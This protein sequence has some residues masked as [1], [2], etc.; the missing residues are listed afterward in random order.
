[1]NHAA[2]LAALLASA[3]LAGCSQSGGGGDGNGTAT[4][5]A[6]T[7]CSLHSA[8]IPARVMVGVAFQFDSN[9]E[10]VG[11]WTSDHVGA[12]IASAASPTPE[13]GSIGAYTIAC[14]H[15]AETATT[16]TTPTSCTLM[17]AGTFY[18]RGHA[19]VNMGGSTQ[20]VWGGEYLVTA[21]NQGS[22]PPPGQPQVLVYDVPSTVAAGAMFV[23]PLKVEWGSVAQQVNS[24]HVGAHYG[25]TSQAT[26]PTVAGYGNGCSHYSGPIPGQFQISC[27]LG[28]A[29][30]TYLR[31][32]ARFEN[33]G[34]ML[35]YWS[36]ELAVSVT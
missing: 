10:C 12:H 2:W 32:H 21:A 19:R 3:L 9:P 36:D 25:G 4:T 26:N 24:D 22:E 5:T 6:A 30:T 8:R 35:D 16:A 29:G 27:T 7:G 20:E 34:Q 31:G 13:A 14:E 28:P 18:V 15:H 33:G 23:M 11:S 17:Q 1:M